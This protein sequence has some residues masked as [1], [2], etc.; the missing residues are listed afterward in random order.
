MKGQAKFWL[1]EDGGMEDLCLGD[2]HNMKVRREEPGYLLGD[3][4]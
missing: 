3:R 4:E 1:L 2:P